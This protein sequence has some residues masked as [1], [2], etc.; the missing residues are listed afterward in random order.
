MKH[1]WL[2]LTGFAGIAGASLLGACLEVASAGAADPASTQATSSF[3]FREQDGAQT[4]DITNVTFM[5]TGS[6]VAGRP[7]EER[8]LLRTAIRTHEVVDEKG[9]DATVTVDAWPLGTDP[10]AKP[11]YTVNV[12]GVRATVTDNALL[13]I[14]RGTEDVD[15]WSIYALGTG[16]RLFDTFVPLLLLPSS[17]DVQTPHYVGFEVPPDDATDPRLRDPSVVGVLAYSS[18]E[19]VIQQVLVTCSDPERAALLRSYWDTTRELSRMRPGTIADPGAPPSVFL[20]WTSNSPTTPDASAST[21]DTLSIGIKDDDLDVA[22]AV[23]PA[24]IALAPWS[25]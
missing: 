15:W 13:V 24:C 23:L 12:D 14:D 21:R 1:H 8:L 20:S 18:A 2:L 22:H 3:E 19:R 7:Q 11:L 6:Y 9:L 25:R 17:S 10:A 16:A 5:T 4:I